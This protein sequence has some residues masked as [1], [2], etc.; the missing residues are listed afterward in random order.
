MSD[1]LYKISDM[2]PTPSSNAI[3]AQIASVK[4]E[5]LR[6]GPM[7]PGAVSLQFQRCGNP[8]CKCMRAKDPERHG[9]YA[10]L[11]YVRRGRS[12]CRFVRASDEDAVRGRVAEHRR[13][14]DLVERW[15]ELSILAGQAD[16]FGA[17]VRKTAARTKRPAARSK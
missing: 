13:F 2:K 16:F 5:L 4:E 12:V 9:P 7:H 8:S 11:T 1:I 15:I 14:R 17:S 3:Q 6:L 10:K